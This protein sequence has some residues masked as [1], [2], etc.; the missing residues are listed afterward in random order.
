[1]RDALAELRKVWRS[2][3]LL[4]LRVVVALVCAAI[5]V[6]WY[7]VYARVDTIAILG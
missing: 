6:L 7:G 3:S 2:D 5:D 1:V 4:R